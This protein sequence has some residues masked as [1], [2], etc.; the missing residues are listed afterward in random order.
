MHEAGGRDFWKS[1]GFH[2]LERDERGRL[3]VTGDFLR[4]Y[5]TRPE[6]HPVDESCA[7]EVALFE[8]LMADPFMEVTPARLADI[9]DADARENYAVVLALRDR[10]ARHGTI[11]AAYL[12]MMREGRIDVPPVFVDQLVHVILRNILRTCR[13]PMRLRAAEIFFRA[14]NVSVDEGRIMLADSEIVEMYAATGGMGGLGQLLVES[15]TA[16]RR[17]EL[18]VLSEDN[19]EIYWARSDR[20]DTVVDFRFTEPAL[21]AF[22]RVIEAWI[23]HFLEVRTRVQPKQR[24]DDEHWRWHIGLDADASRILNALYEGGSGS[25]GDMDR[26]IALFQLDILERSAVPSD[27][28]GRPVYLGL[29]MNGAGRLKMKPQ[30]LLVNLPVTVEA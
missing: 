22:A 8:A 26:I 27:L 4:A 16:T 15:D 3:R 29:A 18:D 7:A 19:K 13:D 21:D 12:A 23:A 5:Y 1:A 28:R 17:V 11:E 14:Q 24:I 6:V 9:A 10:L 20:F 25:A 2:L 30:N